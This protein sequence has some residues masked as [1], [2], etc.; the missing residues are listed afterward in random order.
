MADLR[1]HHHV[2][3]C[4]DDLEYVAFERRMGRWSARRGQHA[5]QRPE[6]PDAVTVGPTH[7]SRRLR[8]RKTCS[9][10]AYARPLQ[11]EE[12]ALGVRVLRDGLPRHVWIE[13]LHLHEPIE[14][15][16]TEVL[17]VNDA[18]VADD[19]GLDA[20]LAVFSRSSG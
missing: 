13:P 2:H 1:F 6:P 14:R 17:L 5:V 19:E 7:H 11:A 16:W 9:D 4:R 10:R 3:P 8:K 12:E 15:G 20:G 18:I